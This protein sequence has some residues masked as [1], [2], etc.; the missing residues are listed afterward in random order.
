M[1]TFETITDVYRAEKQEQLQKLPD[2]FY[3]SVKQWI[4]TKGQNKDM[5]S[6]REIE[7]IKKM[8]QE[9][10]HSRQRKVILSALRTIRGN[11]LPPKEMTSD[12]QILFD[13]IV[14]LLKSQKSEVLEK[15][16]SYD[17]IVEDRI[18]E[19]KEIIEEVKSGNIKLKL[20]D[21]VPEFVDTDM[22][23]LGPFNKDDIIEL[24]DKI[25]D[26]LV[27][28]NLAEKI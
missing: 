24:P 1:I 23:K 8:L 12:E 26:I 18:Q 13:R 9:V 11:F 15:M 2:N 5:N 22:K 6:L 19:V 17:E 16:S 7:N 20:L 28:R 3:D 4:L 14:E 21:N 27:S 10:I 25:A